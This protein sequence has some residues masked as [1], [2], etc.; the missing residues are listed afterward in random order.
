MPEPFRR[1]VERGSAG[2]L[3]RLARLP[4]WLPLVVV[5][6]LTAGGLLLR[7]PAGAA[8][9]AVLALLVGWLAYLSWPALSPAARLVRVLMLGLVI[10][11]AIRQYGLD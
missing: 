7:G 11:A 10:A 9:L 4:S 1:R 6:A 8:L 3:A 5:V 2:V